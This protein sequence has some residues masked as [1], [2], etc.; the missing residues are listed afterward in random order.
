MSML[1][2]LSVL[3][4]EERKRTGQLLRRQQVGRHAV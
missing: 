4:Q 1:N 2:E 3:E